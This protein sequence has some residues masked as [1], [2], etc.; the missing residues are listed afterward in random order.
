MPRVSG[1]ITN[2]VAKITYHRSLFDGLHHPNLSLY[3]DHEKTLAFVQGVQYP[4]FSCHCSSQHAIMENE[5]TG[6]YVYW[7]QRT[8]VWFAVDSLFVRP[9]GVL[10]LLNHGHLR[11]RYHSFSSGCCS[12]TQSRTGSAVPDTSGGVAS[13]RC[14]EVPG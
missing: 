6:Y 9:G 2:L 5:V 13:W 10:T 12:S 1:R 11:L 14:Q 8:I 4:P 7:V 3:K